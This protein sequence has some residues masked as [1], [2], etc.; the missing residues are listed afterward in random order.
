MVICLFVQ[1]NGMHNF[2]IVCYKVGDEASN[3]YKVTTRIAH[4]HTK[5]R[6]HARTEARANIG[7][8]WIMRVYVLM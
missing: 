2:K 3:P 7:V 1:H 6:T 4:T 8:R 5:A